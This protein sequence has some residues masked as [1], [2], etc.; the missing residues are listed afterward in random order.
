M[1]NLLQQLLCV[2]L[3]CVWLL[4]GGLPAFAQHQQPGAP[5]VSRGQAP[6]QGALLLR[7]QTEVVTVTVSVTDRYDQAVTGL[8]PAHFEIFE[9]KVKQ[10][11][12]YFKEEDAPVSIG[13]I[14]DVSSSM[15]GKLNFAREALQNFIETSHPDDDFFLIAFNDRPRLLGVSLTGEAV[16]KLLSAIEA[17]GH[18]ALYDAVH[19]GLETV[20]QGRHRKQALLLLT[21]GGDNASRHKLREVRRAL[22]ES[23]IL[24]YSIGVGVTSDGAT[25][26]GKI[27][28]LLESSAASK[29]RPE[30]DTF[31]RL[32]GG[33]VFFPYSAADLETAA[34]L[35]ALE[36]RR[37]YSLGYVP[38]N[39]EH[40]GKWRVIKLH[41]LPPPQLSKP[42]VR[43]RAG[44]YAAK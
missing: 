15:E 32:T 5:S 24:V 23:D 9:D 44:Y 36:L 18:T 31:A 34:S 10:K 17:H 41:L 4:P 16:L 22:Q 7:E 13:I 43:A 28:N 20:R 40:D 27:A 14:F 38:A 26:L 42:L 8:T 37:Q 2:C 3:L 33:R 29:D 12:E 39:S 19:L 25:I 21:D 1:K 6:A 30:L 11:I 35:I